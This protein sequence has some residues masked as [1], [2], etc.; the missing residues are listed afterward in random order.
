MITILSKNHLYT[1]TLCDALKE[2]EACVYKNDNVYGD[3]LVVAL[4]Q[5]QVDA[6]LKENI[7]CPVLL[8]GTTH[9]EADVEISTPCS[10]S[11]SIFL[12]YSFST[13]LE[14]LRSAV[15]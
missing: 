13:F 15:S 9:E 8:I 4:D 2:F 11:S 10:L 12:L 7:S 3:V 6:L 14:I 1:T 5:E